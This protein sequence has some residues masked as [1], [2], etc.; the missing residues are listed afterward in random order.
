MNDVT[1]DL[2]PSVWTRNG[3]LTANSRT[4]SF[5]MADVD[6]AIS[7]VYGTC[8]HNGSTETGVSNSPT[9]HV[10]VNVS[11]DSPGPMPKKYQ[12]RGGTLPLST[13]R[14]K[15]CHK[16]RNPVKLSRYIVFFALFTILGGGGIS[17]AGYTLFMRDVP[18]EGKIASLE[19]QLSA[20]KHRIEEL[21]NL[22]ELQNVK[23]QLLL[24][25]L[26]HIYELSLNTTGPAPHPLS[27]ACEL[28]TC[29][30]MTD[31]VTSVEDA[32][33]DSYPNFS[34][35]FTPQVSLTLDE[36]YFQDIYCAI[37]NP[38][39]ERNP[40]IA[41]LRHDEETHSASCFCFVVGIESRRSVVECSLIAWRCEMN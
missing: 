40:Q 23:T 12:S 13:A 9:P 32:D 14:T 37:S 5:M 8:C 30:V 21:T 15:D 1:H 7:P 38:R 16:S 27:K 11:G 36:T 6:T 17:F 26:N 4:L 35:C 3:V 10:N 39:S 25:Q 41:T 28:E 20:A 31:L 2:F 22:T 18:Q 29:D 34:S 19:T 33:P 24:L